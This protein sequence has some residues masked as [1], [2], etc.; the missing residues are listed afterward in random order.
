MAEDLTPI[1]PA[2]LP[3]ALQKKWSKTYESALEQAEVD[4]P[5]SKNEQRAAARREANKMLRVSRPES[6]K[7]AAALV[8]AFQK[9][10]DEGWQILAHGER[11]IKGVKHLSIVTADGQR[12]VYPVPTGKGATAESAPAA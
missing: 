7:E 6:H 1:P 3:A 4:I 12:H 8:D 10:K 9:K 11:V 2:N 5:N